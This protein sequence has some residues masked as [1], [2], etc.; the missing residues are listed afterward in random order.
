MITGA[1]AEA[2]TVPPHAGGCVGDSRHVGE[3][4]HGTK[5]VLGL[6]AVHRTVVVHVALRTEK[7][8]HIHVLLVLVQG[9]RQK[10]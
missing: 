5:R 4:L 9:N 8:K 2:E 10:T 7:T 1:H 3:K 6:T